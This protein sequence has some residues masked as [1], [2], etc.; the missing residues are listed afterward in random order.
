MGANKKL[1]QKDIKQY[2]TADL[3]SKIDTD[4]TELNKLKFNHAVTPLD[5]PVSIRAKR[6]DVAR[7]M[8]ELTARKKDK[9]A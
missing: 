4:Q 3:I 9:K 6:K 1:N 8:T 5:N 2:V 7:L